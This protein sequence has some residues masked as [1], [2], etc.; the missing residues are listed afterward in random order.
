MDLAMAKV[1][2]DGL[3]HA[4]GLVD[5]ETMLMGYFADLIDIFNAFQVPAAPLPSE[6]IYAPNNTNAVGEQ[7]Q[8]AQG[9]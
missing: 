3:V 5:Q 6:P 8:T 7:V 4:Q 2:R 1:V 9:V